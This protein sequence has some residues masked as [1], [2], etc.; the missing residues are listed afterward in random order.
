MDSKTEAQ[1]LNI[2]LD[3]GFGGAKAACVGPEG[4]R[5]ATVPSVVGVGQTDLGLLSVG[6]LGRRRR[7]RQPDQVRFEGMTY[8]VGENV[9]RYARPVERMD[10]LRLS[11]GPELRALFYDV[12]FRLL[13]EGQHRANVMAGLPV[14]VMADRAQAQSTVQALRRWMIG[15][16]DYA[17]N[18]D[19]VTLEVQNVLVMA[20]PAGAF[21][22][23]G[24]NDQGKWTHSRADLKAPVAVCDIGFCTLDLFVVEGGEVVGRFTGGDTVGM[25]RAAELLINA[26]RGS[27]GIG[28]S[29]HE[30]D[31]LVRQRQPRLH[32]AQGEQN[33]RSVVDQA[34]DTTAAAVVS[35]V[36]RHWGNGR[37]FAHLL[38]TGGGAEALRDTL[39]RQYPQGA[40][41]PN[42]VTAN[43]LGLAR[44][45]TRVF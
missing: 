15:E 11:D 14:E 44:Y 26:I 13:G 27:Y 4:A 24:L 21:F 10:F 43:A 45:A 29:L 30:A 3:P 38:F 5:V 19:Q 28:L 23:W 12:V 6:K 22:A 1:T 9:A 16:H 36:E 2:G 40:V 31:A 8:L 25:R 42:P 35:F 33:L 17:V 7:S 20:Q 41:L 32:T 34:L 37:Q 18:E 39:L